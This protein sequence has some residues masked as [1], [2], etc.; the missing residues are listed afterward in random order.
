MKNWQNNPAVKAALCIILVGA[1]A[2]TILRCRA[3]IKAK[4]TATALV[5]AQNAPVEPISTPQIAP[6][7]APPAAYESDTPIYGF[8]DPFYHEL[9]FTKRSVK[10]GGSNLQPI[11]GPD[12]MGGSP[13]FPTNLSGIGM[14]DGQV[15]IQPI[16]MDQT[17][18]SGMEPGVEKPALR[19][20]AI[21][22]GSPPMAIIRV[23]D[24]TYF[25]RTGGRFGDGF[26]VKFI[27]TDKAIVEHEGELTTLKLEEGSKSD[28]KIEG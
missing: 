24:K 15:T 17:N 1:I 6:Q 7:N 13:L 26:R 3:S 8:R 22:S 20:Q 25:V 27:G 16:G 28:E 23:G 21:V 9:L 19:L 11:F 4:T 14:Q 18:V 10:S 2:V 5:S 12:Q